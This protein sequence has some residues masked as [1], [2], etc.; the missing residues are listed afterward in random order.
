MGDLAPMASNFVCVND[1]LAC[2]SLL[3]S[4]SGQSLGGG[5]SGIK[6]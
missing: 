3:H 1:A 5:D 4:R 6:I 2:D